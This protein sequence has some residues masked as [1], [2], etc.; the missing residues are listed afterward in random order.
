M[1]NKGFFELIACLLL[2]TSI[3]SAF[4]FSRA[5]H[6]AGIFRDEA[7]ASGHLPGDRGLDRRWA[8]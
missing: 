2:L 3:W 5:R 6:V 1:A 7:A 8:K 4:R